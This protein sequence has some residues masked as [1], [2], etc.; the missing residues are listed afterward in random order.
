MKADRQDWQQ[1]AEELGLTFHAGVRGMLKSKLG[2]RL[3][4]Q[5]G[6]D[7]EQLEKVLDNGLLMGVLDAVFLG[8]II[9]TRGAYELYIYRNSRSS[10]SSSGST[11]SV[12]VQ[13]FFPSDVELGL[14]IYR[15]RFWSKVGKIFGA[16]DIVLGNAELDPMVMIKAN[17]E[18]KAKL[19]LS[20]V[21]VQ[22]ALLE[23]FR[24]SD[25][26]EID[27]NGIEHRTH[28]TAWLEAE[29]VT[30]LMTRLTS[31]ADVLYPVLSGQ[32]LA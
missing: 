21:E 14:S 16:Q 12:H 9:G 32:K 24:H 29:R 30:E 13:L 19:M 7:P 31:A 15:E 25:G 8:V 20:G 28:G 5:Q 10:G 6:Q 23:L 26:F 11:H 3:L 2:A 22:N 4:A 1:L 18:G 17:E 27:D